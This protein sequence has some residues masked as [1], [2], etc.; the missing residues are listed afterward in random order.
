MRG[1]WVKRAAVGCRPDDAVEVPDRE[2][3]DCDSTSV[4]LRL[5]HGTSAEGLLRYLHRQV[6]AAL[7]PLVDV[8]CSFTAAEWMGPRWDPHVTVASFDVPKELCGTVRDRVARDAIGR[9]VTF[10]AP[11]RAADSRG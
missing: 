7:L 8:D 1:T 5:A 2:V 3:V 4:V 11:V 9:A 10:D 6:I